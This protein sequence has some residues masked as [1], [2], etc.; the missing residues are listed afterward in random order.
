MKF[1]KIRDVKSPCRGTKKSAGIDFFVPNYSE[2]YL[3]KLVNPLRE[4]SEKIKELIELNKRFI[5]KIDTKGFVLDSLGRVFIPSGIKVA[6]PEQC[7]FTAHNKGGVATKYGLIFGAHLCDEDYEGEIF[8]SMFNC[9]PD[10]VS[11]NF[12]QKITQFVVRKVEYESMEEV[13]ETEL[14]NIYSERCGE[15]KDGAVGSTGTK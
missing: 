15:R 10:P 7:D 5:C 8:I 11:I 1:A 6:V 13:E 9:S 3:D 4:D 2:D 12:G 14:L